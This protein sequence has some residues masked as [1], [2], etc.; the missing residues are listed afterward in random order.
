MK[1]GVFSYHFKSAR[2]ALF[3]KNVF[4][5]VVSVGIVFC[6]VFTF[7]AAYC[8]ARNIDYILQ[9]FES[10][11]SFAFFFDDSVPEEEIF[12]IQNRL[13]TL[14]GVDFTAYKNKKAAFADAMKEFE[15]SREII[16]GLE[17]DNPFPRSLEIGVSNVN[18]Q[19]AILTKAEEIKKATE[20]KI[21]SV[22]GDVNPIRIKFHDARAITSF[23]K[24][25]RFVSAGAV[26][27]LAGAGAAIISN[28]VKLALAARK[29]EIHIMKYVG[30]TDW[31]IR[32]PFLIE[33]III[34]FLGAFF[35]AAAGFLIY[36][37]AA[38]RGANE[39]LKIIGIYTFEPTGE[40][41]PAAFPAALALGVIIG[42][43]GA[44]SGIKRYLNV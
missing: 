11:F 33:G 28:A 7:V 27:I 19:T 14:D 43:F 18:F 6:C 41:F 22:S 13:E 15:N 5:S 32:W 23:G 2:D 30:A 29:R 4:A 34:G 20:T 8:V 26:L 40:I 21:K 42:G 25:L 12:E 24:T 3:K 44:A 1:F 38:A 9:G 10:S 35:A 16:S 39:A 36:A 37:R 31:F 17:N